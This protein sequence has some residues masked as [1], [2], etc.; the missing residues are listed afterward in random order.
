M[1]LLVLDPI[2]R[3]LRKANYH[4]LNTWKRAVVLLI[5]ICSACGVKSSTP[6]DSQSPDET[7]LPSIDTR[8]DPCADYTAES[9]ARKKMTFPITIRHAYGRTTIR[10]KPKRV[11]TVGWQ[12]QDIPL[13]LGVVPVGMP[14][15]ISKLEKE[16]G[17][18]TP[19]VKDK[20]A[21]LRERTDAI[22]LDGAPYQE[23][24]AVK[25]DVILA[26]TPGL[27][28]EQ[29]FR[30]SSIAPVIVYS[31]SNWE[32]PMDCSIRMTARVL[33][34]SKQGENLISNLHSL[35][36]QTLTK[37][38]G[39]MGKKILFKVSDIN[40]DTI[41]LYTDKSLRMRLFT[42]LGLPVPLIVRKYSATAYDFTPV[43]KPEDIKYL[44]DVDLVISYG[45]TENDPATIAALQNS[46]TY[47]QIPAVKKGRVAVLGDK[48][49]LSDLSSPTP[50][51]IPWGI[52]RYFDLLEK[53]AK[54]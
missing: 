43:V 23:I 3:K 35:L 13:A 37:H 42:E 52:D 33:G 51:S 27:K 29:Y 25:P 49:P 31:R 17:G 1:K 24:K 7:M 22:Y 39:L 2:I 40:F 45:P 19:W 50:L 21:L 18:V 47:G 53:T 30:L 16:N 48:T 34:M 6:Q 54:K 8:G 9:V 20:F 28:Y 36:N 12:S 32:M 15:N 10:K 4:M 38:T 14:G 44:S 26:V 5:F 46:S 11:A 41:T